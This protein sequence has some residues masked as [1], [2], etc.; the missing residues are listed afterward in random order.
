MTLLR[1]LKTLS[2]AKHIRGRLITQQQR[3]YGKLLVRSHGN[4][5]SFIYACEKCPLYDPRS[6]VDYH[7]LDVH[8]DDIITLL[9]MILVSITHERL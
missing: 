2:Y 1:L 8:D 4:C 5:Q 6:N 3:D 9:R 7:C